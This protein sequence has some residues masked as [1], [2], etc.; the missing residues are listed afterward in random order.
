MRELFLQLPNGLK[1]GCAV[2]CVPAQDQEL[3]WIPHDVGPDDIESPY[4]MGQREVIIYRNDRRHGVTRVDHMLVI[5]PAGV[6]P[7]RR[8][9]P[10]LFANLL[11]AGTR[12]SLLA[13]R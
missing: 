11:R 6:N 13:P 4:E 5:K 9:C 8:D 12:S 3:D 1:V 7:Q 10:P 2:E